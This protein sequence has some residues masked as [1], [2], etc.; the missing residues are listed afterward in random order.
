M[1]EPTT[2]GN[3]ESNVLANTLG[4]V[5][6]HPRVTAEGDGYRINRADDTALYVRPLPRNGD[7]G[8]FFHLDIETSY[9]NVIPGSLYSNPN[10]AVAWALR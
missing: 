10:Q 4:T 7:W 6:E 3:G 1:Q 2:T 5:L 8:V 9:I